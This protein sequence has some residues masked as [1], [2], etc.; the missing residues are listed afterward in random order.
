MPIRGFTT[1][2]AVRLAR[3]RTVLCMPTGSRGKV[4]GQMRRSGAM[5]AGR[6]QESGFTYIWLMFTV[7]AM[8][9]TLAAAGQFWR[10]EAQREKE[11]ELIF[12]GDQLRRAIGSYYE[13]SP[14]AKRFPPSLEK[15][16]LD[17]RFPFVKR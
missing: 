14:G 16:L 10:T 2:T 8:G 9:L 12:A 1:F 4:R 6:K 13:S 3:R 11:K 7:A 15:L 5:A 17:D